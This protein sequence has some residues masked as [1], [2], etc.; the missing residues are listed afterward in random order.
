M[1]V[2]S[3]EEYKNQLALALEES[4]TSEVLIEQ[5]ILGWNEFEL[6]VVRDQ[7]GTFV[8]VCSIEN[9][10][11]CGVHTG[12]SITVAPQQTLSDYEYQQMRTEAVRD[13]SSCG[14]GNR[15]R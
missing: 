5:S 11:P 3:L 2:F 1:R 9:I 7:K 13:Y 8:V 10:D 6:E 15:R 4:P 12:D 14:C